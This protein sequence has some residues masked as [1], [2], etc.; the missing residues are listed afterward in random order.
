MNNK[1]IIKALIG[2]QFFT[3]TFT[4]KDGSE[5]VLNG[6]LGVTKH[7]KGGEKSYNDDDFNYLTV[8]D[9]QSKGYRTVNLDT[10]K[11]IKINGKEITL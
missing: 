9:V 5:R 10:I 11:S 4:K 1:K 2:N 7:L 8:Y 3:C 6:R